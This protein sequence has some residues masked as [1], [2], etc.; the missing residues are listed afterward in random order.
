[1]LHQ[2][3]LTAATTP[4]LLIKPMHLQQQQLQLPAACRPFPHTYVTCAKTDGSS[5]STRTPNPGIKQAA[6]PTTNRAACSSC[7]QR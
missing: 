7:V 2:L 1:M 4:L 6:T 5:A 3:L